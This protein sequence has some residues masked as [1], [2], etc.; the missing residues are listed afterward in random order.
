MDGA[1]VMPGA[2]PKKAGWH[3]PGVF[4][5][6]AQV[7]HRF[8]HRDGY[9]LTQFLIFNNERGQYELRTWRTEFLTEAK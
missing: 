9:E 3:K 5:W 7:V 8:N 1:Q 6:P 4:R 2:L